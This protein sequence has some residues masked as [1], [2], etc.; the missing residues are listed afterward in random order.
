MCYVNPLAVVA[1]E[2]MPDRENKCVLYG[3]GG[4]LRILGSLSEVLQLLGWQSD[5]TLEPRTSAAVPPFPS[6]DTLDLDEP[7]K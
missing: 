5:A 4:E 3:A 6:P 1:V 7:L 2:S